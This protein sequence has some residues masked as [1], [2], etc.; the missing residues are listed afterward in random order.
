MAI[1]K[2]D[3]QYEKVLAGTEVTIEQIPAS[4]KEWRVTRAEGIA[5]SSSDGWVA[6]VWDHEGVNEE[7]LFLTYTS[8]VK[9]LSKTIIGDGVKKLVIVLH[10]DGGSDLFMGCG[11]EAR[12]L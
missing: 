2:D 4:G 5:P 8:S 10:N 9:K 12:E 11:Y 1:N 7:I 6:V 3:I